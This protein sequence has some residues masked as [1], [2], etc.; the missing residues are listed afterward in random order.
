[1]AGGVSSLKALEVRFK[2]LRTGTDTAEKGQMMR[3]KISLIAR[4]HTID[5][6]FPMFE[7]L[8]LRKLPV[9]AASW[10]II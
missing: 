1:M 4:A 2:V 6:H 8:N 10:T 7:W 9:F 3:R 5:S